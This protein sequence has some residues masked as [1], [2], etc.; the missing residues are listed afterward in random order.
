MTGLI[1]MSTRATFSHGVYH[2]FARGLAALKVFKV[3]IERHA[4][5]LLYRKGIGHEGRPVGD[6]GLEVRLNAK[7]FKAHTDKA[8]SAI[9]LDRPVHRPRQ[10]LYLQD[11][12]RLGFYCNRRGRTSAVIEVGTKKRGKKRG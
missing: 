11:L 2:R 10:A 4:N 5:Q 12:C 3:F 1:I 6:C 8:A 9:T 7:G